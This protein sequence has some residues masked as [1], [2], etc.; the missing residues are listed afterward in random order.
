M[1]VVLIVALPEWLAH[2]L[3]AAWPEKQPDLTRVIEEWSMFPRPIDAAIED[4][5]FLLKDADW[6]PAARTTVSASVLRLI[7]Q[8]TDDPRLVRAIE[9]SRSCHWLAEPRPDNP[10]K[11]LR[12][13]AVPIVLGLAAVSGITQSIGTATPRAVV[14]TFGRAISERRALLASPPPVS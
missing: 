11:G 4:A 2:A 1:D 13:R 3:A 6:I 12:P 14:N 9:G 7:R 10:V 5:E 8:A